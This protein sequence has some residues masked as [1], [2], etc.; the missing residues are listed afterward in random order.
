MKKP[1][2]TQILAVDLPK[3]LVTRVKIE[4]AR[5]D[6]TIKALVAAALDAQL[7]KIDFVVSKTTRRSASG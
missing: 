7:A 6:T 2:E 5:T 3:E 4:S 1:C